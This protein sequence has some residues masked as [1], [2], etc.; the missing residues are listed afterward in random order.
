MSV[1]TGPEREALR[2]TLADVKDELRVLPDFVLTVVDVER[3]PTDTA[4]EDIVVAYDE[5]PVDE[6]HR[7]AAI[8]TAARLEEHDGS[9]IPDQVID[10]IQ[11]CGGCDH[12]RYR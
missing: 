11:R 8:A 9:D 12:A 10:G 5:L 2:I 4:K 1:R 6:A 3:T 7:K